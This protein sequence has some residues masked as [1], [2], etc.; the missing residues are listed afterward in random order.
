MQTINKTVRIG[1]IAPWGTSYRASVY[2]HIERRNYWSF[3]GVIGP[4]RSGNAAGGCGQIDM[5]FAHRKPA[6]NDARSSSLIKPE[7]I[8]FAPGW[9]AE[10]LFT[11]LEYWKRYHLTNKT[12][13]KQ[14]FDFLTSLPVTDRQ[15]AWV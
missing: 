12:L 2:F 3:T 9:D 7:E 8:Q 13:P 10:K 5:E 11:L 6:D 15:P 14:V 4:R 1:T